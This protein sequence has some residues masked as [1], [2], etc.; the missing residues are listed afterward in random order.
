[1]SLMSGITYT[2]SQSSSQARS[3]HTQEDTRPVNIRF[4]E[5]WP[6]LRQQGWSDGPGKG[7]A[8]FYFYKPNVDKK[9]GV[10]GVDTFASKLDV[11]DHV[12]SKYFS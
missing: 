12:V 8:D 2:N 11:L 1:M 5:L 7:L 9:K 6:S 4:T 3:Q 10:V